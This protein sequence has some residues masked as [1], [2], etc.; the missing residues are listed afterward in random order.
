MLRPFF[1]F[2]WK[3][4]PIDVA[5]SFKLKLSVLVRDPRDFEG[6]LQIN[7]EFIPCFDCGETHDITA[8]Q[9]LVFWVK[10]NG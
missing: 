4:N 6:L 5:F 10:R 3:S 2:V 1:D 9:R 8:A 7:L